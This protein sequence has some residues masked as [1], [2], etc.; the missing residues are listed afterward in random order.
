MRRQPAIQVKNAANRVAR[1][2]EIVWLVCE[3]S[4][5]GYSIGD[6]SSTDCWLN[7]DISEGWTLAKCWCLSFFFFLL[8]WNNNKAAR[9][10]MSLILFSLELLGELLQQDNLV[11]VVF[12]RRFWGFQHCPIAKNPSDWILLGF[13]LRNTACTGEILLLHHTRSDQ[14][15][16]LHSVHQPTI[17]FIYHDRGRRISR[18]RTGVS[19]WLRWY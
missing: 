13:Y 5:L 15:S 10:E 19:A 12:L 7:A 4:L 1:S 6:Y 9:L 16:T 18:W 17:R 11:F 2:Q 3:K 14:W 8:C